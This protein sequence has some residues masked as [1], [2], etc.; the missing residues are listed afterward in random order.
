MK[1]VLKIIK[2]LYSPLDRDQIGNKH[3]AFQKLANFLSKNDIYLNRLESVMFAL[4]VFYK[5]EYDS[6]GETQ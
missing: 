6:M 4:Y 5:P 3:I 1:V 2:N